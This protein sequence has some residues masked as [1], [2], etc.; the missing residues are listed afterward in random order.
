MSK[1]QVSKWQMDKMASKRITIF[2]SSQPTPGSAAYREARELGRLLAQAGFGVVNGGYSGTMQGVSQGATEA[3]GHA[4]GVTCAVFDGERP[5]GNPYLDETIHAPDLL[6]R[7]RNLIEL[8][9]GYVV[10]HGGVG[11][12]LELLLVWNLLVTGVMDKPCI[13]V[14]ST[15]QRVLEDLGRNTQVGDRHL[16]MLQV[17]GTIQEAVAL[18]QERIA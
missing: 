8:G 10:L 14:G 11:T 18:L 9:D 13:L 4:T 7:L 12:L 3:G 16:A 5:A 6:A 17:V 2:G 1:Q 15:W